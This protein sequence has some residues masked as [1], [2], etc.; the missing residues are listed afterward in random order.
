VIVKMLR[1]IKAIRIQ[2]SE[3]E[4]AA[5]AAEAAKADDDGDTER[6]S[7]AN[8]DDAG[9]GDAPAQPAPPQESIDDAFADAFCSVIAD[10]F[11]ALTDGIE[12]PDNEEFKIPYLLS[13]DFSA[14]FEDILRQHFMPDLSKRCKG[15]TARAETDAQGSKVD[16]FLEYFEGKQG[17]ENMWNQWQS[18]WKEIA[19]L[20][21]KPPEPKPQKKKGLLSALK[22]EKARPKYFTKVYT[23]EEWKEEIKK[24]DKANSQVEAMWAELC[25][26]KGT[27]VPPEE[28]KDNEILMNIFGRSATGI[29]DQM[30]AINQIVTQS[31]NIGRAFDT[32]QTNKNIDLA[33]MAASFKDAD[34]Y[35]GK[36]ALLK[37]LLKGHTA[38]GFP[39]IA[40]FLPGQVRAS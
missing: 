4:E 12:P 20:R 10:R 27:Y 23:P 26:D 29:I 36:K 17:R 22:K 5:E 9:E 31:E 39:L 34:Q 6:R 28:A 3:E 15:I 21:E 7:E 16:F 32:Y 11:K 24:I 33:L 35:L 18:C 40:R 8:G 37:D 19:V 2:K 13:S 38:R 1:Q 14:H 25:A 30:S